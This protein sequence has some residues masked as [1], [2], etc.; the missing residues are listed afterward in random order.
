[1]SIQ[2]IPW[3]LGLVFA[4]FAIIYSI[5][6]LCREVLR[7]LIV[8]GRKPIYWVESKDGTGTWSDTPPENWA[9]KEAE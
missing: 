7:I 6:V 4:I 5:Y 9:K 2:D 3:I 8:R 1:M